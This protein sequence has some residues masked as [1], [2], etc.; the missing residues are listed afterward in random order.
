VWNDLKKLNDLAVVCLRQRHPEL[1]ERALR[2]VL[3]SDPTNPGVVSNLAIALQMQGKR[4]EALELFEGA[5]AARPDDTTLQFNLGA[6]LASFD[7]NEQALEHLE[8]SQRLGNS[9]A[10]LYVAK[11]KVLVR[12]G[13]V[14][15]AR[16]VLEEGARR[17]PDDAEIRELLA[18]LQGPG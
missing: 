4:A 5:V 3:E 17:H 14:D 6:M 15:D 11:S 2:R 12:L 9:G 10:R 18:V 8:A 13:R 16:T 7:R 1:A